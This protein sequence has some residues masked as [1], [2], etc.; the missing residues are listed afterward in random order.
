MSGFGAQNDYYVRDGKIHD[1]AL[2]RP[3]YDYT[4]KM[5]E[6]YENGYIYQD[7][8]SRT[9]DM[10]FMP[11]P[12]LTYSGAVGAWYALPANLGDKMSMPESGLNFDVQPATSPLAPGVT[13]KDMYSRREAMYGGAGLGPTISASCGHPEKLLAILDMFYTDEGGML[14][15]YGLAKEQISESAE[16]VMA[17][18]GLSDGVYWFEGDK[19]VFNPNMDTA[20]GSV[21]SDIANGIR[22]PG[23]QR[24]SFM[25]QT[26][27]ELLD[28]AHKAWDAH[29]GESEVL[30]LPSKVSY[31][32]DESSRLSANKTKMDDLISEMLPKFIMGAEALNEENWTAFTDKLISY[33]AEENLAIHQASYDRFMARG[34]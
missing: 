11:N 32:V 1:G 8:A 21:R 29:D 25:N 10:P 24:I 30:P 17:K 28:K 5:R 22:F 7:F 20:G 26:A 18:M 2:E 9:Q 34:K 33:G 19:F 31:T 4:A 15:T 23:Y 3:L 13:Y 16:A 6:W 27:D 12:A 14:R